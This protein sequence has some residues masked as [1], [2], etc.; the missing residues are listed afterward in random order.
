MDFMEPVVHQWFEKLTQRLPTMCITHENL[1]QQALK[2]SF[3]TIIVV[4]TGQYA[5]IHCNLLHIMILLFVA[6]LGIIIPNL[7][8]LVTLTGAI[9]SCALTLIF[10]PLIHVLT[11]WKEKEEKFPLFIA[12][13]ISIIIF[14][15]IGFIFGTFS[16][17]YTTIKDFEHISG[18]FVCQANEIYC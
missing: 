15:A 4:L 11:F 6:I 7:S 17:I 16:A 10:P 9:S 2:I 1:I 3:R 12:K 5:I 13:D 18:H 14:G 8:D